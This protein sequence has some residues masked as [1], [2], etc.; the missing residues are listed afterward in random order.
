MALSEPFSGSET[1]LTGG[2]EHSLPRDATHNIANLQTDDGVYQLFLDLSDMVAGD[3]VRLKLYEK[4]ESAGT[5]RVTMDT[6]FR[7]AQASPHWASPSF[8][9]MHGWDITVAVTTGTAN[10]A[11]S[12]RKVA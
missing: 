8:L 6:C 4:V 3:V 11:W 9:L 12:I 7:N 10:I 1:G 2:T 5:C